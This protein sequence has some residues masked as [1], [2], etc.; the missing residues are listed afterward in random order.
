MRRPSNTD[1]QLLEAIKQLNEEYQ[2][3]NTFECS[4][5]RRQITSY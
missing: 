2:E 5:D 1:G 4:L 3:K